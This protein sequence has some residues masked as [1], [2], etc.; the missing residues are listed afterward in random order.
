MKRIWIEGSWFQSRKVRV[1]E[2]RV[3]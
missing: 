2:R 3:E 1:A